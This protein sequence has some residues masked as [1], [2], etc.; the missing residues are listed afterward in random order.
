[1]NKRLPLWILGVLLVVLLTVFLS[2]NRSLIKLYSLNKERAVLIKEKQRLET[3]N[4]RLEAE[5]KRL[6]NDIGY[7]EKVAREKYNLKRENEDVYQV[8]PSEKK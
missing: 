7:I 2:G 5:I 4:T 6:Q 3:E 8:V 1:M